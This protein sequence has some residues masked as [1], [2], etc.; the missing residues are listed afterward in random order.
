MRGQAADEQQGAAAAEQGVPVATGQEQPA[1]QQ[2]APDQPAAAMETDG[3]AAGT[4]AAVPASLTASQQQLFVARTYAAMAAALHGGSGSSG[5]SRQVAAVSGQPTGLQWRPRQPSA[6]AAGSSSGSS[7][8][9]ASQACCLVEAAV[10]PIKTGIAAEGAAVCFI[11]GGEGERHRTPVD[12]LT[13]RQL[14]RR[15]REAEEQRAALEEAGG[16]PNEAGALAAAAGTAGGGRAEVGD[17]EVR[18]IGY[19]L[20]E[21]PRGAP[22][23]C[24]AVAAVAAVPVCRLR[25]LQHSSSR[26]GDGD[27]EAF[28][29]NPGSAI[30]FPVRLRLLV[31][32]RPPL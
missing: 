14:R 10:M 1:A 16:D 4:A 21:V 26:Q 29:R 9:Q 15:Q 3:E 18:V 2:Q 12:V 7:P 5:S 27:I 25:A 31:E 19:V 24:G 13:A 22:R 23:R 32:P 20:S 6:A 17:S 8:E 11:A 30:L 28:V